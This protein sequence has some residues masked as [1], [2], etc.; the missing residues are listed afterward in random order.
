MYLQSESHDANL[1]ILTIK[2]TQLSF[3]FFVNTLT[4]KS[5]IK[6]NVSKAYKVVMLSD[7]NIL[8][9]GQEWLFMLKFKA[10]MDEKS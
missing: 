2:M 3:K 1:W 8:I 7:W 10:N 6:A 4:K 5:Q 9:Q